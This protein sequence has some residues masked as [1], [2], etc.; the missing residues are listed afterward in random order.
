MKTILVAT[1]LIVGAVVCAQERPSVASTAAPPLAAM[2]A[3]RTNH[4]VV[5]SL[6]TNE[7]IWVGNRLTLPDEIDRMSS[8]TG[9]SNSTPFVIEAARNVKHSS[10]RRIMDSLAKQ[11]FWKISFRVKKETVEHQPVHT[12]RPSVAPIHTDHTASPSDQAVL[13]LIVGGQ[14][15]YKMYYM[16]TCGMQLDQFKREYPSVPTE[17]WDQYASELENDWIKAS[18]SLVKT[19]LTEEQFREISE[20]STSPTGRKLAQEQVMILKDFQSESRQQ[21][22]DRK[23][24]VESMLGEKGY[25]KA[26]SLQNCVYTLRLID[27]AKEQYA[28]ANRLKKGD[29]VSADQISPYI[30][31]GF[32]SRI[33]P[34]GGT[35]TI[36]AIGTNPECSLDGHAL[37]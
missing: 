17:F 26:V 35:Y 34:D 24:A 8:I 12:R 37:K 14:Q 16:S 9:L 10:I 6:D 4:T 18:I 33:C 5:I 11:Q 20:F 21:A 29:V 22:R 2:I 3:G 25:K 13:E 30:K 31:G 23:V 19:R 7:T 1:V 28:M 32:E 36:N 27:S 15:Q